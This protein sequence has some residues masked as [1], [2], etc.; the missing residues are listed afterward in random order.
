MKTLQDTMNALKS[1][2]DDID[3][4]SRD[5][6]QKRDLPT[7]PCYL[8]SVG[9][10]GFQA[11]VT[12][13]SNGRRNFLSALGSRQL[14]PAGIQGLFVTEFAPEHTALKTLDHAI[15]DQGLDPMN[16]IDMIPLAKLLKTEGKVDR[17]VVVVDRE[18]KSSRFDLSHDGRVDFKNFQGEAVREEFL[19]VD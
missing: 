14:G 5:K 1:I 18:G 13:E 7:G 2:E 15:N 17:S 12:G 3:S 11:V 6:V 8:G 16:T 19:M 9:D 4:P 10:E